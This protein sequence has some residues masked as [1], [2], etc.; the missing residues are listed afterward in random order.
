MS[1]WMAQWLDEW[2]EEVN[3]VAVREWWQWPVEVQTD[4]LKG[5]WTDVWTGMGINELAKLAAG[6][7]KAFECKSVWPRPPQLTYER[8]FE[9]TTSL[10]LQGGPCSFLLT[11]A[12]SLIPV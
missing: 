2:K 1:G 4:G 6:D 9:G 8:G 10:T 11:N 7:R 5:G 12:S 3:N